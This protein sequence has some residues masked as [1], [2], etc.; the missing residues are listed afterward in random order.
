MKLISTSV[1]LVVIATV[2]LSAARG[3][4]APAADEVALKV[5]EFMSIS[6]RAGN[7]EW[8]AAREGLRQAGEAAV[9]LLKRIA[10]EDDVRARRNLAVLG[11]R[12]IPGRQSW[13]ALMKVVCAAERSG[14]GLA[15]P[16]LAQRPLVRA[17]T[18]AELATIS[19][20]IRERNLR[21]SA[22]AAGVLVRDSS[23]SL[24]R[25]GP[26]LDRVM[27]VL[28]RDPEESVVFDPQL[29]GQSQES[30]ALEAFRASLV[31]LDD[32]SVIGALQER[33][34]A[35]RDLHVRAWVVVILGWMGDEESLLEL[36]AIVADNADVS[37]RAA[38]LDALVPLLGEDVRPLL[39]RYTED[40]TPLYGP[41]CPAE[42]QIHLVAAA[43]RRGLAA[44]DE[45]QAGEED[46]ED[47]QD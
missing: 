33:R 35:T 20:F 10:L 2:S 25:L 43:A 18:A 17:L 3:E 13:E 47:D 16:E 22:C 36:R 34:D 37:L 32:P 23:S 42:Q 6:P 7:P 14:P 31:Q 15:M 5:Q 28:E 30:M 39:E 27:A 40:R 21:A 45:K 41:D 8:H 12:E 19:A 11:L 4:D 24:Q 1:L 44:L 38:A 26:I 9:P 46:G 29:G